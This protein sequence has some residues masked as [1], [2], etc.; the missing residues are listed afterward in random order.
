MPAA[1]GALNF[2][3]MIKVLVYDDNEARRESLHL[4]I[5]DAPAMQCVGAFE[6]CVNVIEQI[7]ET[8]PTV[9]LMDI[10]MPK[11]NG[12][13]GVRRI[14]KRFPDVL[15]IMQTV[16]D[17][18]E[19]IFD[20]IHAGANGYIL[21]K[22]K[23]EK[24]ID[25]ITDVVEG[26]APMTA[27]VAKRV[28]DLFQNKSLQVEKENAFELSVREKEILSML[29]KGLSYKMIADACSISSHTVNNH[30]KKIYTKLHVHSATEAVSKAFDQ[31]LV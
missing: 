19:K 25:S 26:G 10:D 17:E 23:P 8:S 31:G 6:N 13:E 27:S 14:R 28:L 29:T 7:E 30:L 4:L 5:D 21:K 22:I 12:I 1:N 15:I 20:S 16:F 18:D 11:V 3:H 2:A 9:I 24:I